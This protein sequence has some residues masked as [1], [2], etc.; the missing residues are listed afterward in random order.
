MG[1]KK[2]EKSRAEI[3]QMS[4]MLTTLFLLYMFVVFPLV[5]HDGYKD[6]TLTKYN[7]FQYGVAGYGILMSVLLLFQFTDSLSYAQNKKLKY[8]KKPGKAKLLASDIWMGLFF[9]SGV[10]AWILSDE[11]KAAFTGEMGRRCGL[12]F[13]ILVAVLYVC[14]GSGYRL[15]PFVLPVFSIVSGAAFLMSILQHLGK[16]VFYLRAAI[17]SDLRPIFISTFGNINIFASFVCIAVALSA[18]AYLVE[19]TR[20]RKLLYG[21][22]LLLGGAAMIAANSDS[23]YFGVGVTLVLLLFSAIYHASLCQFL[24]SVTLLLYGY[25]GMAYLTAGTGRGYDTLSGFARLVD[26]RGVLLLVCIVLTVGIGVYRWKTGKMENAGKAE[27]TGKRE[28]TK[29]AEVAGKT[30]NA[31]KTRHNVKTAM[32]VVGVVLCV[33]AVG[34]FLTGRKQEWEIFAFNDDWG[35]YRGYVWSRL[36]SIYREFPFVNKLFGNGN[37][38]IY[39]LMSANYQ[40]E[41]LAVTGTVYDSAHNEYLQYLVTMGLFGLVSYLGLLISSVG[42]CIKGMKKDKS[43]LPIAACIIAYGAQAFFN[44]EQPVTTPFLFVFLALAAGMRRRIEQ[45]YQEN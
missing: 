15:K 12:A 31:G 35:N 22:V 25:T 32:L 10:L 45:T 28:R 18:G 19:E 27:N 30:E 37:E 44:V 7:L 1:K 40:E 23:T 36:C 33:L 34:F 11:K 38:S 6:I 41:M 39:A 20:W 43:F 29:K 3:F 26:C 8:T 16:D 13:L 42:N 21:L 2:Y 4:D 17:R 14:M 24:E 5:M 9:L